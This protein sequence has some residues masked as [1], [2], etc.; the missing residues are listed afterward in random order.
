M[1]SSIKLNKSQRNAATRLGLPT[2]KLQSLGVQLD[3]QNKI[4][5]F[6]PTLALLLCSVHGQEITDAVIAED[7]EF[8]VGFVNNKI[9]EDAIKAWQRVV[10]SFEENEMP[11][12]ELL[13]R[14]LRLIS[15]HGNCSMI[16]M[17]ESD[18][19]ERVPQ[20]NMRSSTA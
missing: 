10:D 8:G 19:G 7:G 3:P 18:Y 15:G 17:L 6:S 5:I 2:E 4:P 12:H 14:Y 20:S 1:S 11:Y 9:V 16:A 13:H